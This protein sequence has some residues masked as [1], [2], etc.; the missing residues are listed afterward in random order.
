VSVLVAHLSDAHIKGNS[1]SL[2]SRTGNIASV[3]HSECSPSV[4]V[5]V[6]AFTGDVIDRGG[7][8]GLAAADQFFSQLIDRVSDLTGRTVVLLLIPGNHDVVG[9]EDPSAR[10]AII[11]TLTG[12]VAKSRPKPSIEKIVMSSLDDYFAFAGSVAGGVAITPTAASPYYRCYELIVGESTFR[13]HLLNTAWMCTREQKQGDL[14]YPIPEIQPPEA[15]KPIDYE[16]ALLHHPFAWFKQPEVM[17]QL[18]TAIEGVSDLVLTGHEHVGRS[19]RVG[20]H[21]GGSFE[22]REGEVLQEGNDSGFH[23]LAIDLDR[24]AQT[25]STFKWETDDSN[26]AYVRVLGPIE[27]I[28][29]RNKTRGAA[30][31]RLKTAFENRLALQ[32]GFPDGR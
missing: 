13:F 10:D 23:L 29:G 31:Y 1:D 19:T 30:G 28:I 32:R 22:Y 6:L 2:L 11:K 16:V 21:G 24:K 25:V 20:V 15:T 4:K 8:A 26:G 17:R 18:R 5:I 3:I 27:D 14:L 9:P 12:D 7:V